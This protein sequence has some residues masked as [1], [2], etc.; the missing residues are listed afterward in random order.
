ML[1]YRVAVA[2]RAL[3]FLMVF[4]GAAVSVVVGC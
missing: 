4:M 3:N 1:G 2:T